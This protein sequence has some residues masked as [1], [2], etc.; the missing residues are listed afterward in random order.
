MKKSLLNGLALLWMLV[1][2]STQSPP[3][4]SVCEANE[5]TQRNTESDEAISDFLLSKNYFSRY[6]QHFN[7]S[8]AMQK[9]G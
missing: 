4:L 5:S 1:K 3:M 8:L 9:K 7:K 2:F 6:R